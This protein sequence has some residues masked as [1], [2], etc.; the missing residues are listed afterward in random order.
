M[1]IRVQN[2]TFQPAK[3]RFGKMKVAVKISVLKMHFAKILNR[4]R[5]EKVKMSDSKIEVY[6]KFCGYNNC[7]KLSNV[8]GYCRN[9]YYKM[10]EVGLFGG[11][12][13][14][15]FPDC[16]LYEVVR[17]LCRNHY[18]QA[19]QKG[20]IEI[21]P[22]VACINFMECFRST[23]NESGL[24][25]GCTPKDKC[26]VDTCDREVYA[27]GNCK[28]H[29]QRLLRSGLVAKDRLDEKAYYDERADRRE[30]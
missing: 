26:G 18:N 30:L 24:C 22:S 28:M 23:R 20:E 29:Y 14:C 19:R 25:D 8:R 13:R 10:V 16:E 2:T 17:G 9:H 5:E 1:F 7:S 15:A 11:R 3:N 4:E 6:D 12:E 27:R 21:A